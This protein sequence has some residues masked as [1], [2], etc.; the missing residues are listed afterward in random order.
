M[1]LTNEQL[2]YPI[3]KFEYGKAYHPNDV[4]GYI[5]IIEGLPQQLQALLQ[6]WPSEWLA[7]PYREGG[8]T[9]M[10]TVIHL[11]D[12]HTN[13][14]IRFKLALTEQQPI[15]KPYDEQAWAELPDG[16]GL[17]ITD[18]LMALALLH[19]RWVHLMRQMSTT[20]WER[21]YLH[22]AS[23]RIFKLSEVAA[24][25]AWHSE[26]HFQHIYRLAVRNGWSM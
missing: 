13:A 26:H 22:P 25:Y 3:G 7:E 10:Q 2:R 23:N 21:T 24:L 20:D 11:L 9:V 6:A 18:I 17:A 1:E 14:Y 4:V 8:W 5:S 15:I 16:D 12:S 19:K